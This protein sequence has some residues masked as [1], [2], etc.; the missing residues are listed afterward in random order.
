MTFL[1][2]LLKFSQLMFCPLTTDDSLGCVLALF[3][4]FAPGTSSVFWISICSLI[5]CGSNSSKLKDILK[6][7]SVSE[8]P[9]PS[10]VPVQC[11]HVAEARKMPTY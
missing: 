2:F 9:A 6:E 11:C 7:T 10:L 1:R 3:V 4:S 8:A 5:W